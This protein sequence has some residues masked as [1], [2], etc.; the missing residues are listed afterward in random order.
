VNTLI[1]AGQ[2][3][4]AGQQPGQLSQYYGYADTVQATVSG[5]SYAS[6]S[7]PYTI[8]AGEPSA[9]AAYQLIC[10][11]QCT[12]GSAGQQ[13]YFAMSLNGSQFGS[14]C[15]VAPGAFQASAVLTWKMIFDLTCADGISAWW[16]DL[17]GVISTQTDV[18]PATQ[19]QNSVPLASSNSTA[20]IEA[21]SSAVTV[22]VQAKWAATTGSP[23][24]QCFKTTF[25]K[26]A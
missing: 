13:L 17:M 18:L 22:A 6:L 19:A 14:G 7:N 23:V 5:T 3:L 25:R 4:T 20:K 26:V 11:G 24:I 10:S 16:G 2:A 9:N 8:P 15:Y 12:W 21:V 1:Y